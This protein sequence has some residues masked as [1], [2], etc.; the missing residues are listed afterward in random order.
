MTYRKPEF[1][2]LGDASSVIHGS[3][4]VV[5]ELTQSDPAPICFEGED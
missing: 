1:A 3:K 5:G 4:P 2:L